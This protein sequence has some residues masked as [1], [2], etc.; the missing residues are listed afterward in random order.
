MPSSIPLEWL[1]VIPVP[2]FILDRSGKIWH[3]NPSFC[4]LVRLRKKALVG[5]RID[6]L[7]KGEDNHPLLK[8]ILELYRGNAVVRQAYR[9]SFGALKAKNV[10]MDLTPIQH[11]TQNSIEYVFGMV[12]EP[13]R[14]KG[15][16][17]VQK[18]FR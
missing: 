17:F 2:I 9:V 6:L 4:G 12:H 1:D 16:T 15:L 5:K 7:L 3:A 18:L 13:E 10:V 11:P 14:R 8:D